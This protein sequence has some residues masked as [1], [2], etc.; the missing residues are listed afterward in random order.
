MDMSV[1]A[2]FIAGQASSFQSSASA[3]VFQ[4]SV[5]AE[6]DTVLTIL[7]ASNPQANL[8]PGVGGKLDVSA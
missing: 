5:K 7:G 4:Q 3:A 6:R 8:G 2:N 1:V